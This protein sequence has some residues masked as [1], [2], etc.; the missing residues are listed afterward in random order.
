MNI[1]YNTLYSHLSN[2]R[3]GFQKGRPTLIPINIED[4]IV[5]VA[6]YLADRNMGLN[7]RRFIALSKE[8]YNKLQI[9]DNKDKQT[10]FCKTWWKSFKTRHP[11]LKAI[12]PKTKDFKRVNINQRKDIVKTFFTNY[13]K[14]FHKYVFKPNQIWNADEQ[15]QD[16]MKIIHIL[17]VQ[18][19]MF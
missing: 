13:C 1:N 11:E 7:K 6:T 10:T 2:N 16:K 3:V 19:K 15:D 14:L 17:S 12:R 5:N 9:N 18:I 8:I 4:E